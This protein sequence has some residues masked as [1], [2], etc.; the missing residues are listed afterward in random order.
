MFAKT[1]VKLADKELNSRSS[2]VQAD[3]DLLN[4]SKSE[5]HCVGLHAYQ[6]I[7]ILTENNWIDVQ[8]DIG[9][10]KKVYKLCT[11]FYFG[12]KSF[13]EMQNLML[14]IHA[15]NQHK[16]ENRIVTQ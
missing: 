14:K 13:F 11:I 2:Y 16:S 3:L 9:S 12:L 4:R 15:T 8:L 6:T 5:I 10:R 1:K 7:E